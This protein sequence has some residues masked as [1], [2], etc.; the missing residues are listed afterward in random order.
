[1]ETVA[2]MSRIAVAGI[3]LFLVGSGTFLPGPR[4]DQKLPAEKEKHESLNKRVEDMKGAV[5]I[6]ND[7][8]YDAKS[9]ARFLR[10]KWAAVQGSA[11]TAKEFVEKVASV[12]STSGKPYQI[13]FKDG[14]EKKSGDFLLEEL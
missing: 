7:R 14:T 6:R 13:R 10:E 5:F 3:T 8:E 4:A 12:S 2:T 11:K 9:A 1:M